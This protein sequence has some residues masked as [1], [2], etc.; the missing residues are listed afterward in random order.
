MSDTITLEKSLID[1]SVAYVRCSREKLGYW[2]PVEKVV[3]LND[4]DKKICTTLDALRE[5][6]ML[7]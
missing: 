7:P 3:I 6:R 1:L 2:T 4:L 5:R